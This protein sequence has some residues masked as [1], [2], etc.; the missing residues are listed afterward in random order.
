[1]TTVLVVCDVRIFREGLAEVLSEADQIQVIGA[2]GDAMEAAR[3][4]STDQPDVVLFDMAVP[5]S[6]E[7]VFS[8]AS[9]TPNS[10][11]VALCV[12]ET[13]REVIACAEAGVVGFVSREASV[14]DLIAA[15]AGAALGEVVCPPRIAASLVREMA[16]RAA[17]HPALGFGPRLTPRERQVIDL[18]DRGLSNKEIARTLHIALPTVKNH[19]HNI[20]EKC[21]VHRRLDAVT[22]MGG[23]D[24]RGFASVNPGI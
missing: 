2:V 1:M 18:I 3:R 12:P 16:R 4:V 5:W 22:T 11:L 8:A 19:V 15:V 9:A 23:A 13:E 14:K 21:Q 24:R 10:R 17:G 7:A 20:L 6:L